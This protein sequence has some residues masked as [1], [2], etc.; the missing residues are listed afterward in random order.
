MHL[1][2]ISIFRVVM[3]VKLQLQK[4]LN[5]HQSCLNLPSLALSKTKSLPV[6]SIKWLCSLP[7]CC[8][9]HRTD[10]LGHQAKVNTFKISLWCLQSLLSSFLEFSTIWLEVCYNSRLKTHLHAFCF[11]NVVNRFSLLLFILRWP[12]YLI[13][14]LLLYLL[15]YTFLMF[16]IFI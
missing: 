14:F 9:D 15:S 1:S 10:S 8:S 12:S 13:P 7:G 5:T 16:L 2:Q 6:K 4:G 11:K 3:F